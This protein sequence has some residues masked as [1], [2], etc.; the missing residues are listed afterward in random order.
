VLCGDVGRWDR[1]VEG[2]ILVV[3]VLSDTTEC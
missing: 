3:E 1:W 2:Q